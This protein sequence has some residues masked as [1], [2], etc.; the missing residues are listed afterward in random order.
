ML[1]TG[2]QTIIVPKPPGSRSEFIRA[3]REF[4]RGVF[5]PSVMAYHCIM[6]IARLEKG[7]LVLIQVAVQLA[8]I[9]AAIFCTVS[10][11]AKR[12]LVMDE[13]GILKTYVFSLARRGRLSRASCGSRNGEGVDLVLNS[14][15][16][17]LCSGDNINKHY[18]W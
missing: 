1:R 9:G 12:S 4:S 16:G 2:Q 8:Q 6:G 17:E 18:Y 15:A 5:I 3:L 7:L 14:S 10:T 11:A 13:C